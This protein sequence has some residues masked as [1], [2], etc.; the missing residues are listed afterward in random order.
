MAQSSN[1]T[2]SVD[3]TVVTFNMHGLNQGIQTTRDLVHEQRPSVIA[4]QEHWLTPANMYKLNDN[5][6]TYICA[7]VSAMSDAVGSGVLKGRPFGGVAL[8]IDKSFNKCTKI[9]VASERY[10]IVCVGDIVV[11]NAYFPCSGTENRQL[12]SDE[13]LQEIS[14][15]IS[16][17]SEHKLLFCGDFNV[18]LDSN[19][20]ISCA[21][22]NF[23]TA[24]NMDRCDRDYRL[25]HKDCRTFYNE[26]TKAG[27]FID[28]IVVS[29]DLP[30]C[31][32][33]V[34]DPKFN[35]SDHYPVSCICA[36]HTS[37]EP[38]NSKPAASTTIPTQLRWDK[39]NLSAYRDL[40]GKYLR[41]IYAQLDK[42]MSQLDVN[43]NVL[44]ENINY[45][46]EQI[47]HILRYCSQTYVPRIKKN[48]FKF[49]WDAELSE[50]KQQS[51]AASDLWKSVGRPNSGDIYHTHRKNKA[52]YKRA[53]HERQR[54]ETQVYS[55]ELHD[56]LM[57][58]QGPAF[59][60]CWKAKFENKNHGHIAQVNGI[61]NATDIADR[62]ASYFKTICSQSA[63]GSALKLKSTYLSRR[64]S[65]IGSPHDVLFS[66]TRKRSNK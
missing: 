45:I 4:L 25:K 42:M 51:V 9:V 1:F 64:A 41:N 29:S 30:T 18:D 43:T 6:P 8:L 60:K 36:C 56:A 26:S 57:L 53:I 19:S 5:F 46:Y 62:F 12:I 34:L 2:K 13:I 35:L 23:I 54:N 21:L 61:T 24:N 38:T 10:V 20:D 31:N 17:Y 65:Y 48:Y 66:L 33:S 14:L 32:F 27:S 47:V 11:I 50:L 55:N 15:N 40:T 22:N 37:V 44:E 49:W 16:S 59:W 3:L 7:G 58:K 39:A 28:Y 63:S 52:A